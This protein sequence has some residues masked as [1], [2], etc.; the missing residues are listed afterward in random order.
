MNPILLIPARLAS[1]RLPAK[2]LADIGGVPMIVR[3]WAQAMKA[4]VG[5]VIVSRVFADEY[6]PNED[7]V[8][9]GI[10]I[11]NDATPFSRVVGV[12]EDVRANGLQKPPINAVYF[13]VTPATG[14]KYWDP[15]ND[16]TFVL[17]TSATDPATAA[18]A[19]PHSCHSDGRA[20]RALTTPSAARESRRVPACSA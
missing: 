15:A 9:H 10:K 18:V 1:T 5:P 2:P 11:N 13:P 12:A 17:R 20:G 6:W 7:P 19:R 3:V 8:G 16:M 14:T 4:G